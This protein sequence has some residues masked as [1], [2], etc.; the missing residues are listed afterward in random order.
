M[1]AV[2]SLT[3][4][5]LAKETSRPEENARIL[6]GG[7]ISSALEQ[8]SG[9]GKQSF[10]ASIVENA[11]LTPERAG[12]IYESAR[13]LR[14]ELVHSIARAV[15]SGQHLARLYPSSSLSGQSIASANTYPAALPYPGGNPDIPKNAL[16]EYQRNYSLDAIRAEAARERGLTGKG[17]VVGVIDSGI[18]RSP[19]GTV[20]PE[21]A[22]R[23]DSRSTSYVHWFD[24]SLDGQTLTIEEFEK[25]FIQGP[26]D[27]EALVAH[28]THVSGIIGAG[29]NGFG[30][31]GVAPDATIISAKAITGAGGAVRVDMGDGT[32]QTFDIRALEVCGADVLND[33]CK[34]VPAPFV[35]PEKV[36]PFVIPDINASLYL[37]QF[38]DVKVINMSYGPG[39]SP[40]AKTWNLAPEGQPDMLVGAKAMRSNLDAGQILVISAGNSAGDYPKSAPIVAENPLGGGL[41]PFIQPKNEGVT[42]S[43]GNLVYDDHGTGFDLSFTSAEALAA[44]EKNDG[45]KRGRIVVVVA[46]D[47]YNQISSYS[48]RC[49]VAKEWCVAAPGGGSPSH[50]DTGIYSTV[51]VDDGSYGNM[52]GTSMAAPNVSGAVAILTEAYPTFSPAKIVRILFMTAEDLGASGV[53]EIYGWG[54]VRL[55][56]A[57]SVA[58]VGMTGDGVYT[59]GADNGDTTWIVSFESDGSLEKQGA[60]TLAIAGD[61]TFRKGGAVDGG[62]LAVDG[63]LTGAALK[64]GEDGALGGT[65]FIVSDVSVSGRLSPGSSPGTLTVSGNVTLD[66]TATTTIEVDGTG[67]QNGAGNYDRIVLSGSGNQFTAGG[68]LT[69]QLRGIS[70]SATNRFVPQPGQL[71]TFVSAP[72][73]SVTG[74]FDV[75]T[76]PAAGLPEAT[77]FDVLYWDN[78]LSLAATPERYGNLEALGIPA[79]VNEKALGRAIDATRPVAGQR[80]DSAYN[81]GYNTLYAASLAELAAGLPSMTGQLHAEMATA[82]V[83]AIGRFADTINERQTDPSV[84]WF[85]P[86]ETAYGAGRAWIAGNTIATDVGASGGLS[87]YDTTANN[88][89]FGLDW[90]FG[91]GIAGVAA[92]YEYAKVSANANG[93][94]NIGTYQGALYGTFDTGMIAVAARAGLSYGD[95]STSRETSL[96]SYH[97]IANASGHGTGGFIEATA[98]HPFETTALTLTPSATFGYRAFHRDSMQE[99]GSNL[100]LSLPS[101]TFEETQTTIAMAFSKDIAFDS[102]LQLQ[103]LVS[104]GWRHDYGDVKR[105]T[106]LEV[107]GGSFS[108]QGAD[109]GADAFVGRAALTARATNRLSFEAAYEGEFRENLQSHVFSAKASLRF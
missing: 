30:M 83:R 97:A 72:E 75:L 66:A 73:G 100:G 40:G 85:S 88:A 48:N 16:S 60:G 26:A 24:K 71:F 13:K 53:D 106:D 74:S 43:S 22:G 23:V 86:N 104:L 45:L 56:R 94:G 35:D 90:T 19:D 58:P 47:A 55:D 105:A 1:A 4:A 37:A 79:G 95:L 5:A 82:S 102:G 42:N 68:T 108:A 99:T 6:Q 89:V 51:P 46:L 20:H 59:V 39:V 107:F 57:L 7:A 41:Y 81:S 76:Q 49:G 27:T 17:V 78:A 70:G 15:Q 80:P 54:L 11:R 34:A 14:P 2:P 77:R 62:L 69:P 18:D 50:R 9:Y 92:S 109:I 64:I 52:S 93:S 8:A 38:S 3:T 29:H 67:T 32:Y 65:G 84:D 28:G 87:G 31:E 98:F 36:S 12:L 63:S 96:G 25:G 61:A 44:A 103:P 33:V 10:L 91:R 101:E 21:F